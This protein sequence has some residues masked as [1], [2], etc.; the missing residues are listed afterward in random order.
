[1]PENTKEF[2]NAILSEYND[3]VLAYLPKD[4]NMY[5]TPF[6]FLNGDLSRYDIIGISKPEDLVNHIDRKSETCEVEGYFEYKKKIEKVLMSEFPLPKKIALYLPVISNGKNVF[7][8][9]DIFDLPEKNT[10]AFVFNRL[11]QSKLKVEDLF[12]DSYKDPLTGL[13]NFNTFTKHTKQNIHDM[14]IGLFD[15]NHF[16]RINDKYGH[17]KGDEV[18]VA[19]GKM[20]INFSSQTEIFYHRSGDEFI[21]I[22]FNIER[23]HIDNLITKLVNGLSCIR[24]CEEEITAAFGAAEILHKGRKKIDGVYDDTES[25]L[26]ADIAMYQAKL[27]KRSSVVFSAKQVREIRAEGPLSETASS[28]M[29]SVKR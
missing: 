29:A 25:L 6:T 17:S 23:R 10:R 26:L 9:L 15:L 1:M 24:V 16:K 7:F 12:F 20:L 8:S 5:D 28:L 13:F 18:L 11:D 19:I 3:L 22:S 4:T 14:Y 21:F 2:I 27:S